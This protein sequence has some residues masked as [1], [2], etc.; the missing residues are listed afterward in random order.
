MLLTQERPQ[1]TRS[2][3]DSMITYHKDHIQQSLNNLIEAK[4]YNWYQQKHYVD[5]VLAY[6]LKT[7][8]HTFV[9]EFLTS[10]DLFY[11]NI[12]IGL[13]QNTD[14]SSYITSPHIE[15]KDPLTS[16]DKVQKTFLSLF[17]N[18][19]NVT[20]N[21]EAS[22]I[23]LNWARQHI[24]KNSPLKKKLLWTN[25]GN[26]PA[27]LTYDDEYAIF[28]EKWLKAV[29]RSSGLKSVSFSFNNLWNTKKTIFPFSNFHEM[30]SFR[31]TVKSFFSNLFSRSEL[32][33]KNNMRNLTHWVKRDTTNRMQEADFSVL[34]NNLI[35]R[36]NSGQTNLYNKKSE[37]HAWV[38]EALYEYVEPKQ[39]TP[40]LHQP[41]IISL[42][43]AYNLNSKPETKLRAKNLLKKLHQETHP[44]DFSR[45]LK[46]ILNSGLITE[47][48]DLF[49][50][51]P[52]HS[53]QILISA[54]DAWFPIPENL[55]EHLQ[56][57]GWEKHIIPHNGLSEYYKAYIYLKN[58]PSLPEFITCTEEENL[59][60]SLLSEMG[61]DRNS[62]MPDSSLA[63]IFE[64]LK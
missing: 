42:I 58:K 56:H 45:I 26:S 28:V 40:M 17:E 15:T 47:L 36:G 41:Q 46:R 54:M 48:E 30:F 35:P 39:S 33:F 61:I 14:F 37:Y 55:R 27:T 9:T 11:T 64:A 52:E 57:K 24:T 18:S 32:E 20:L 5:Y 1:S 7:K 62:N 59:V 16:F 29:K 34:Y 10:Q 44:E 2:Y 43:A 23:L 38:I 4:E 51:Y 21:K 19:H 60:N 12:T 63:S 31:N 50:D 13:L 25:F 6:L 49:K 3:N 22:K 53:D 8:Q